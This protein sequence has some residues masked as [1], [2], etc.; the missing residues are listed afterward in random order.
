MTIR[1]GARFMS[2]AIAESGY[3]LPI[4]GVVQALLVR[5]GYPLTADGN[6]GPRTKA[7]VRKFQQDHRPLADDGS[8]SVQTWP[9][10]VANEQGFGVL[11]CID[12]GDMFDGEVDYARSRGGNP[13]VIGGMS[14]GVEQAI[15][16]ILSATAPRSIALLRFHG[17]GLPGGAGIG[18]GTLENSSGN[19]NVAGDHPRIAGNFSRLQSLFSP[20]GCIQFMHCATGSGPQG[21][22]FLQMVANATGVPATAAMRIQLGGGSTT[23]RYEGPTRTAI[24]GG[25]TLKTWTAGLPK[26]AG[27]SIP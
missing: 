13:L 20:Y 5:A 12:I 1:I 3:I 15:S 19:R 25:S 6:F 8:V 14:N 16:M 7:A 11:D 27:R 26:L 22:T 17:H 2:Y 21:A 24:P 9:R 23:F 18:A 10:L 4:A